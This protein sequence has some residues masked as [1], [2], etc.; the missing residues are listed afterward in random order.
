MTYVYPYQ[1]RSGKTV[2]FVKSMRV[3]S[4]MK[5]DN[6]RNANRRAV[7]KKSAEIELIV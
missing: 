6:P 1:E 4:L 3:D 5:K 2:F 7:G